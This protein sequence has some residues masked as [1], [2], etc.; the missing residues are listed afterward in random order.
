MHVP[1]KIDIEDVEKM[2][3]PFLVPVPSDGV[4]ERGDHNVTSDDGVHGPGGNVSCQQDL[5]YRE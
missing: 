1:I 4:Q 5:T 2:V 3:P